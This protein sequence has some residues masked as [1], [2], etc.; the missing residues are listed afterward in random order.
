M[1]S[2]HGLPSSSLVINLGDTPQT[3]Q[4]SPDPRDP[5]S[6]LAEDPETIQ[7]SAT[8]QLVETYSLHLA[9]EL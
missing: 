4:D 7:P 9:L 3:I 2:N 5:D 6:P 8:S 1:A